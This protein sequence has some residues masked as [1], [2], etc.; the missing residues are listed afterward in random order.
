M[1]M[2]YRSFFNLTFIICYLIS[3]NSGALEKSH[4]QILIKDFNKDQIIDSL[5]LK[6]SKMNDI[7]IDYNFDGKID[8]LYHMENNVGYEIYFK[9]NVGQ[10]IKYFIKFDNGS[11]EANYKNT[12][13]RFNL[14][15]AKFILDHK[16]NNEI[17]CTEI[18]ALVQ[19]RDELLKISNYLDLSDLSERMK[20]HVLDT[21][22][23]NQK[24]SKLISNGINGLFYINSDKSLN[25]CFTTQLTE[26]KSQ[27]NENERILIQQAA[28]NLEISQLEW[29]KNPKENVPFKLTC[30][31]EKD[32]S[33]ASFKSKKITG[34][35]NII[36]ISAGFLN[37][38]KSEAILRLL[39]LRGPI[40]LY[41]LK[42]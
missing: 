28:L 27:Y 21:S 31:P 32:K 1:C 12:G 33:S 20:N 34:K 40:M 5:I 10:A 26:K 4:G 42:I 38:L 29:A 17:I 15:Y 24:L 22:C 3:L 25:T 19:K 36:N 16:M 2:L 35:D 18:V 41:T 6:T 11:V 7:R 30:E 14:E 9:N 23:K 39:E 13:S 8:Y 37:D